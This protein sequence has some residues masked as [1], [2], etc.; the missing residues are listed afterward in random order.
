MEHR[1]QTV[2]ERWKVLALAGPGLLA[3]VV[4]LWSITVPSLWRDESVTAHFARIPLGDA[5]REWGQYDAVHAAHDLL[6]RLTI[7]IDPVEL[8]LRLPSVIAFV[9]TTTGIVLVGRRLGGWLVG[10]CSATVYVLLPVSSRYAQEGRSYELVAAVAVFTTLALLR[11]VERPTWGRTAAYGALV[12]TLGCL[13]L[14]G[15]L[16]L[17][18][19]GAY[20]ALSGRKVQLRALVAWLAAG[21][22]LLPL[23][24]VAAGQRERQLFWIRSPGWPELKDLVELFGG[25][26]PL[27]ILLGLAV[28]AGV[29]FGRGAMLPLLWATLP[30]VASFLISQ[31]HP[32]YA[33]RYVL[34]VVPAL[35]LLVGT[36][37]VGTAR[38]LARGRDVA[39]MAIVAVMLAVVAVLGL[40]AQREDRGSSTRP[41]DLRS[42]TRQ[43]AESAR[44]GDVLVPVPATFLPFVNAYGGPFD[45]LEVVTV[46]K[47]PEQVD[48]VWVINRGDPRALGYSELRELSREFE[49]ATVRSYGVTHL[50]LWTRR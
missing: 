17:V 40:P 32:V 21:L 36:G 47:I 38:G 31:V 42:M 2:A 33:D 49:P 24:L 15:L 39:V 41:D 13:H 48:R 29:W 43:V 23:V 50:S 5:W 14:Y 20:I 28:L 44:P 26:G 35:A 30:V 8:G 34:F 11:L 37:I 7:W 16:L 25:T 12:A 46:Q 3:A 4:G 22:L 1:A 27:T 6:V 18:A 45:R 10:A 9:A 19:H